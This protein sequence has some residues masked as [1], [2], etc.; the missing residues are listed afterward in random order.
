MGANP[1]SFCGLAIHPHL[2]H[3]P[4]HPCNRHQHNAVHL[5]PRLPADVVSLAVA[6]PAERH[7][8]GRIAVAAPILDVVRIARLATDEA[9]KPPDELSIA[10]IAYD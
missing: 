7:E 1:F 3:I 6:F 4:Q 10:F 2:P 5:L 9:G 8:I